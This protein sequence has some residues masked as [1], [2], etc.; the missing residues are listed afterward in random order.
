MTS[1]TF[2]VSMLMLPCRGDSFILDVYSPFS[3]L[4]VPS[5]AE[6]SRIAAVLAR[7]RFTVWS[8]H[9]WFSDL[10]SAIFRATLNAPAFLLEFSGLQNH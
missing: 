7:L 3:C 6:C 10:L 5:L 4:A 9:S 1:M 2:Y 8:S